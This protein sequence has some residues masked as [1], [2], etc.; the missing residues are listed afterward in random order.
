MNN[1]PRNTDPPESTDDP[2]TFMVNPTPPESPPPEPA[3][4][5]A[6]RS[7]VGTGMSE[8]E[9][10]E[11]PPNLQGALVLVNG[12]HSDPLENAEQTWNNA[13]KDI[14][15]DSPH[16]EDY[17]QGESANERDR[18][19]EADILSN[20]EL[21]EQLPAGRRTSLDIKIARTRGWWAT[22]MSFN[23]D[24]SKFWNY[25]N[26]KANKFDAADRYGRYFNAY[27]NDHYING[28]HGLSS[29]A[30]HRIDHGVA[31]GYQWALAEW[32]IRPEEEV[33]TKKEQ[34]PYVQSY[35]PPYRPVTVVAHSHGA[36]AGAGVALG[37]L[38]Y[39]GELGWEQVAL[40]M[41]FLGVHQP[42][43]LTGEEYLK[44]INDKV[45]YYEVNQDFPDLFGEEH[46]QGVGF[47]NRL[48][49][50][51]SR[52]RDKLQHER[53]MV[54]HLQAI[55]GD[56]DAFAGRAIQF[57]FANDRAD[58]VTRDGDIPGVTSACNP[59][60]DDRLF[61]A[62]YMSPR[63]RPMSYR[64]P[65]GRKPIATDT[66]G[67][68]I[69]SEY[70][71]NRRFE[72]GDLGWFPSEEE[73]KHGQEWGDFERVAIAWGNAFETYKARKRVFEER[74]G[75]P[76][77]YKYAGLVKNLV[78]RLNRGRWEWNRLSGAAREFLDNLTRHE[79]ER[80]YEVTTRA[81]E[82][83]LE[84][85][86][87]LQQAQL[88]AHSAPVTLIHH[89]KVLSD[90]PADGLG[91]GS[92]WERIKKAGED[93][94]YRVE[95]KEE[96]NLDELSDPQKRREEKDYVN[97]DG[98]DLLVSTSITDTSY[99]KNVIEVFVHGNTEEKNI[100]QLYHEPG[101]GNP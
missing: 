88:Y 7:F 6:Y 33:T 8:L 2:N 23:N 25:W 50:L 18:A 68:L 67:T 28:S 70:M 76:Y 54:E 62:E 59:E 16:H 58:M 14:N 101:E 61:C 11:G 85:Y 49:E 63:R 87:H 93:M 21:E 91:N 12:F 27:R 77:E 55:T 40:N 95:Y 46:R 99:I 81:Y 84:R 82:A 97:G 19:D 98:K 41:I 60:G 75:R 66:S 79:A 74:T 26:K 42:R 57:T 83:M 56:W 1:H 72:Y 89:K 38:R 86:A 32:G 29:N 22:P 34:S 64:G 69:L 96:S 37:F 3:R 65:E 10:E 45:H 36:A 92:I 15:P 53:G 51:F 44:F 24:V 35:S 80:Q 31:L 9:P 39:A 100:E 4:G 71:A 73:Q 5:D 43:K 13:R 52:S 30:A 17:R 78:R 90:F 94:F 47:L 20:E 48:A